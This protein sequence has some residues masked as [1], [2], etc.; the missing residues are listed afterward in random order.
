[1]VVSVARHSY[2]F[3]FGLA[4]AEDVLDALPHNSGATHAI[5]AEHCLPETSLLDLGVALKREALHHHPVLEAWEEFL[6]D[7]RVV[8]LIYNEDEVGV[9]EG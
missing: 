1:M 5:L 3:Y 6:E 4:G 2:H 8:G 9:G 7:G